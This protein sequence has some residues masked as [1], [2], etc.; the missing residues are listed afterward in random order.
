MLILIYVDLSI[1]V[2]ITNSL[3]MTI[4]TLAG[5]M[6]GEGNI[7]IGIYYVIANNQ[8][9]GSIFPSFKMLRPHQHQQFGVERHIVKMAS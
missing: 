6:L 9:K 7:N 3:T 8:F 4:T 1:A 5:K 2:P